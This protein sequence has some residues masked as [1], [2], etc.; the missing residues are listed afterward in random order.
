[1]P[2]KKQVRVNKRLKA[3]VAK[4]ALLHGKQDTP[5]FRG[6]LFAG[7]FNILYEEHML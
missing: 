6:M 5:A 2:T 7:V 4:V 3:W 1:M